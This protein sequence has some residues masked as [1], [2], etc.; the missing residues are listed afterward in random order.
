M[1]NGDG[2]SGGIGSA[3]GA[4]T[5]ESNDMFDE[6][7]GLATGTVN[8]SCTFFEGE[9][10]GCEGPDGLDELLVTATR[11]GVVTV[12]LSWENASSDLNLAVADLP[13][14]CEILEVSA[15]SAGT[16]ETVSLSLQAGTEVFVEILTVDTNNLPEPYVVDISG[17][18][19]C[20]NL[21]SLEAND[22][23]DTT[24]RVSS[25]TVNASC[26]A[27]AQGA[28]CTGPDLVDDWYTQSN[29]DA[30][31]RFTLTWSDASSDLDLEVLDASTCEVLATA[32]SPE[33]TQETVDVDLTV[34]TWI[35]ISVW[36]WETNGIAQPYMLQ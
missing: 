4:A 11:D 18:E 8:G 1:D 33:G 5:P 19:D 28:P 25:G 9:L 29:V 13:P 34:G 15:N 21:D 10:L 6:S 36:P 14:G 7:A 30:T 24:T 20:M 23:F 17:I 2:G 16:E 35:V 31:V 22:T 27:A 3:C 12:D 26:D 32:D